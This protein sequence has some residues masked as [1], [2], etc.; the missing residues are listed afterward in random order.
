MEMG[1]FIQPSR[2]EWLLALRIVF[3][4]IVGGLIGW[5]RHRAGKP[6]GVGTHALVALGAAIFVSVPVFFGGSHPDAVSRVIQGVAT[7]V[8]FIGAGEIF[9]DPGPRSRV[10]GLTTAAALWATAAL[11]VTIV[12]GSLLAS[13]VL[14]LLVLGVLELAPRLERHMKPHDAAPP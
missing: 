10:T 13:A 6:A 5:N 9:R 14:A 8:G 7:G 2:T 3:A 11:G 1:V 4:A 12:C